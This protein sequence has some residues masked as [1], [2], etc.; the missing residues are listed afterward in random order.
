MAGLFFSRFRKQAKTDHPYCAAIVAAAGSAQRMDGIDKVLAELGGMP[1]LARTL[2]ALEN[3]TRIDEI[4]IVTRS[5]LCVPVG[6]LC[7]TFG[8]G[9][10]K[11]VVK[12]GTTR[13]ESV[14]LG[15]KAISDQAELAAIH[16]GARPFVSPE[17]L[18]R[19]LC[20][21]AET[22][23]AAPAVPVKDTV[24]RAEQGIVLETVD[25]S[26]LYAVQTPQVFQADFI[27]AALYTCI[28]EGVELTDDCSAAEHLGKQV[29]LVEGEYENMKLTTPV[30]LAIGEA[31][32]QWQEQI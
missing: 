2:L 32:L 17:L 12:G 4:V 25:R 1:V 15:L 28:Q 19:V 16:D 31:I 9:K 7:H 11:A 30:D 29:T 6:K 27:S 24:K 23:A 3:C 8:I 20:A 10:A 21:A 22:G 5:D 13:A 26:T 18:D 14:R